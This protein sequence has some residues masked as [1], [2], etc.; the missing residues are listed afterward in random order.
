MPVRFL[1]VTL[2]GAL[3]LAPAP[4]AAADGP[5]TIVRLTADTA[6]AEAAELA[7]AGAELIDTELRLWRLEP[8]VAA[9]VLPA[10]RARGSVSAAQVERSYTVAATT[11]TPDPLQA[12]EWWRAQIGVDGLTPPGPGVPVTIVDSGLDVTHPEF[13]GRP[14]TVL[15]NAQEPASI[16]GEHGTSVASLVAAPLNG[17]GLVGIYPQAV[18]RSWDAARG[19]GTRLESSDISAGILAAARAGRGVINLSIGGDRDLPIELAVSEAIASGSL[20]VAASGNDGERGSQIGYP[21]ALPHVTTVAATNR[22][23]AVASFSSRSRYVDVAAPGDA[24][25]VASALGRDWRPSSGT[26]FSAPIVAGAAAWLWTVRPELDA[27]QVAELLRRSARDIDQPGRDPVS[28][29]GMLNLG[30]AIAA[31]APIRDPFEPNDDVEEVD[32]NGDRNLAHAAALTTKSKQRARMV[33]RVDAYEDPRDV[34]RVWLPAGRNVTF[35]VSGSGDGDLSLHRAT[36]TTVSG[37]FAANGRLAQAATRGRA[38]RLVY[39]N[40]GAGRWA[41]LTVRLPSGALD[42]TYQLTVSSAR[43]RT[44]L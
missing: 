37:R 20:V 19:Q 35:Q 18:L 36:A 31:P 17:V 33:A 38:E 8:D 14:D 40:A 43:T 15:L 30:A 16:G 27:G 9:G 2:L 13:S 39:R 42:T 34:F 44:A 5:A 12:E 29:F 24:I 11:A 23:G 32:P 6:C 1:L 41:Y 25:F 7:A 22:S 10:L 3:T 4:A 28:G 26:S 21:A